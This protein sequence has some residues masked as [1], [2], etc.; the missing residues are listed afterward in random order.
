M[1]NPNTT[2]RLQLQET[3]NLSDVDRLLPYLQKL[4]ITTIYASPIF[5]ATPGSTHGYDGVDPARVAAGIG[6]EEQLY[7]LG[8]KLREAGMGWLQDIVPNHM[9]YHQN[10]TWLMDLLEKGPLSRY[11]NFF[12]V[13]WTSTLFHGRMMAPF[14]PYSLDK[15]IEQN[16]LRVRFEVDRLVL[17]SNDNA[18]PLSPR[19]YATVLQ[20]AGRESSDAL[21]Q[22]LEGINQLRGVEEPEALAL[23]WD[24]A[25]TQLVAL[26]EHDVIR[27]YLD[28][29]LAAVNAEPALIR[30]LCDAQSYR[31]C[32]WMEAHQVINYRRFFTVNGLIC[33]NMQDEV[34]FNQYHD[35][36]KKLVDAGA[37]QGIRV[38]HIDG[39]FDP[40]QYLHRL[41]RLAGE[42]TYILVEKIQQAGEPLPAEWPI[43]GTTGYDF[44]AD[45]NNLLTDPRSEGTFTNFYEGLVQTNTLM[46]DRIHDRK[47]FI[48][49]Q[50]MG[51]E[52]E[53]LYQLFLELSL[54]DSDTLASLTPT[55]LKL[56]IGE[57]LIACPVYRYYGNQVPL[58]A[59]EADALR[60]LFADIRNRQPNL[61]AAVNVLEDTL[62]DKPQAADESLNAR[63]LR[64]Y[65]RL[66]QF[67]GP[68]M[69]K[70]VEDTLMYTYNR[71]IGHNEVGDSPGRF[72]MSPDQFHQSMQTRQTDWPLTMNNLATHDT[73]RGEDTRAR[74]A[75]LTNLPDAWL[76]EVGEWQRLNADSKEGD[77]PDPNDEFFIYQSLLGAYAM[78]GQPEEERFAERFQSFLYKAWHEAKRF[79]NE[80]P[81]AQPYSELTSKFVARLLDKSRPFWTRF[82]DFHRTVAD[83]GLVNSLVQVTLKNTCPGVPDLYQGGELWDFSFVDPDNRRPVDYALRQRYLDELTGQ[84]DANALWTDLWQDR[85]SGRIKLCL[86][87]ILLQARKQHPDLFTTGRYVP[88]TTEGKHSDHVLA[89]ARTDGT[90]WYVVA[91]PL[92]PA[93]LCP[94]GQTD[95]LTIDW[96]DTR[97]S[98]PADAPA[99]WTNQLTNVPIEGAGS[100]ALGPLFGQ[101]PVALLKA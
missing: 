59:E 28:E 14:L 32:G 19:S 16:E 76:A 75:V 94:D 18:F 72:G 55:S 87:Y 85:F 93:Q 25:R 21:K 79:T 47:A 88:L 24:E 99:Q 66:M 42:E 35:L 58:P 49:Y 82:L 26:I 1:H 33:L 101:V 29:C 56:A 68:L 54:A 81:K 53:N 46:P 13:T 60:N 97:V 62:L 20:A 73:K 44:L 7:A 92:H 74:L 30:K 77:R 67:T 90:E 65:Q 70:G 31:L 69:A 95:V 83:F 86:T 52:F 2:Y 10:N 40:V 64:F 6:T 15:V 37:I 50:T 91:V 98:L 11:V 22:W 96:Q 84:S 38:D 34:V 41:R 61:T 100:V 9:A 45:V 43:Q 5:E 36:I 63:T 39:L 23:A 89:F 48:L 3:F 4:G 51:G 71:F 17:L 57:L 8:Q 27:T 78:P 12:D 80:A